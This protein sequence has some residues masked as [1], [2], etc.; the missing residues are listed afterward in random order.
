[1]PGFPRVMPGPDVQSVA[2]GGSAIGLV[3]RQLSAEDTNAR[4][5]TPVLGLG[6]VEKSVDL[7]PL[8]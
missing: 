2:G 1:V 5:S 3:P 4:S 7:L 6:D 8:N